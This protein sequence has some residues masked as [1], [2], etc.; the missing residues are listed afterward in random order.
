LAQVALTFVNIGANGFVVRVSVVTATVDAAG[1]VI[2]V[3]FKQRNV[4]L[5]FTE[6]YAA[7]YVTSAF[8]PTSQV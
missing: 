6:R 4:I 2:E 1:I 5:V 7:F 3:V 8:Y